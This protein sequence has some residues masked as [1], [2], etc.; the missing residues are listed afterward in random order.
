M[1]YFTGL[2][3]KISN[4]LK[5]NRN[6]PNVGIFENIERSWAMSTGDVI[7]QLA[8]DDECGEGWFK[9]VV[10]FITENKIDY[11][12][13]MFCIYGDYKAVYPNGDSFIQNN[14]MVLKDID[15]LKLSIRNLIENRSTCYG[16]KVLKSF[17]S[18]FQGRSYI[19]ESAQTRQLQVWT[20]N[21]YYIPWVGNIYYTRLGVSTNIRGERSEQ[22]KARW[23]YLLSKLDEWGIV[24][25][26]KDL[27][28]IEYRKSKELGKRVDE[29]F[30]FIRSVDWN[31]GL[32]CFQFRRVLFALLRRLPHSKPIS[33]FRV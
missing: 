30:F 22:H 5:L 8:G 21:N 26:K 7:Y 6:E 27:Y 12:N 16:I 9:K 28:Y 15:K 25:D 10:E 23:N 20:K 1:G 19:A 13:D 24:L 29:I 32:K 11:K 4:L 17:K 14:K 18:V 31:L 3:H 2:L 33:E